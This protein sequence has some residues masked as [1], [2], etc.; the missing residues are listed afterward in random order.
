MLTRFFNN[1]G[2]CLVS[3]KLN[4]IPRTGERVLLNIGGAKSVYE[5]TQVNRVYNIVQGEEP[6]NPLCDT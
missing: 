3:M 4:N 1:L 6:F 2:D 5:I